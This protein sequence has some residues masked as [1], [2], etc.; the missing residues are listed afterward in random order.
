MIRTYQS[1]FPGMFRPREEMPQDLLA[2]VRY[3]SM[4]VNAQARAYTLYH[5]ENPQTFYNQEDLWA[6]ATAEMAEQ[7]AEP[8]T[9]APYHVLMDL[10][11]ESQTGL[12]FLNILPFTPAGQGRSNMVGWLAARNDGANYGKTIVYSFPKNVTVTGPAQIRARVNQDPQLAQLMTL[13]SQRGSEILR[14]SLIVIPLAESLLYVEAF[15]LQAQGT[16]SKLPELRQVA[17]A[18]QDRLASA[19][20]F[21]KALACSSPSLR[22]TSSKRCS[23]NRPTASKAG[24]SRRT[25]PHNRNNRQ[26]ASRSNPRRHPPPCRR[27]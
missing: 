9:M 19:P 6:I 3:P 27:R 13:W 10:P 23:N 12:E 15:F 11:G 1:I 4:L 26:P 16:E 25:R 18:T 22:P 20:T 8:Q 2:H 14:G 5:I 21:E 7:G 24:S 17:V